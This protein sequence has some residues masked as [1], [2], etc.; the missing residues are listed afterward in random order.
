M[1]DRILATPDLAGLQRAETPGNQRNLNE[2]TY[3]KKEY[4]TSC[5][6]PRLSGL[7]FTRF[8]HPLSC[9][10]LI[11]QQVYASVLGQRG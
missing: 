5:V 4:V 2:A 7:H 1:C 3:S 10:Q 6:S 9:L 8:R 11:F